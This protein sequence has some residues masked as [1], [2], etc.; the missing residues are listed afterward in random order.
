MFF[1]TFS[2]DG[3]SECMYLPAYRHCQ[4]MT[5]YSGRRKKSPCSFNYIPF[6]FDTSDVAQKQ[7]MTCYSSVGGFKQ[8]PVTKNA[9]NPCKNTASCKHTILRKT[10]PCHWSCDHALMI[11]GGWNKYTNRL[12]HLLN[13]RSIYNHLFLHRFFHKDNIKVFFANNASIEC[14]FIS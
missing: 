9:P 12:R 5:Q 7:R 13:M 8:C 10:A 2:D 14:K 1:F 11:S 6:V 3:R 4:L